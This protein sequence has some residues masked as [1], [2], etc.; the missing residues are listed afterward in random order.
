M[1]DRHITVMPGAVYNEHVDQQ[2][3]FPG[4]RQ[5][6]NHYAGQ[7]AGATPAGHETQP[8]AARCAQAARGFAVLVTQPDKA[9]AILERLHSLVDRQSRPH[10]V[11]MPIRAAME[12]G[13]ISR[14][15]WGQFCAEFGDNKVSS[16]S[17][18]A[19]YIS[20]DYSYPGEDFIETVELFRRIMHN[21]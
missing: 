5:V 6:D 2:N 14:P 10:A 13:A 7:A 12:A 20:K 21:S 19:K 9:G 18:L 1:G 3:I 8:Q 17:L 15:T 4:L 11:M 16:K